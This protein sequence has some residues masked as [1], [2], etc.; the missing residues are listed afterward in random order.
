MATLLGTI[1]N[2]DG[3]FYAKS[4][5]G[6]LRELSIGDAI[7]EGEIVVGDSANGSVD[8]LIVSMDDGNDIVVLGSQTQSF[9]ASLT[10]ETFSEDETVTEPSTIASMLEENGDLTAEE[11]EELETAAGGDAGAEST[12]GG[13]AVF[14]QM[15]GTETDVSAN[16]GD[17]EYT[18]EK[19][20]KKSIDESE[21]ARRADANI[22]T[23]TTT[24]T[25]DTTAPE[26]ATNVAIDNDG[27]TVTGSGEAGT[28]IAPAQ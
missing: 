28:A 8:S 6:S 23:F 5:D 21:E 11:L 24:T 15:L 17:V 18:E 2:L 9:D 4:Q 20:S 13:P 19:T 1:S 27:L 14:A 10:P 22:R 7:Y 12:D 16:I 25:V 26:A 3:K